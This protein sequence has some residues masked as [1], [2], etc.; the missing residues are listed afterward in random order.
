MHIRAYPVSLYKLIKKIDIIC[1]SENK[2]ML[3]VNIVH[4]SLTLVIN[5]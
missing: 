4:Y 3:L 5:N 1:L 2:G